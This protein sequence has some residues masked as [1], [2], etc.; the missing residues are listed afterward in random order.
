MKTRPSP[1]LFV[2]RTVE[3]PPQRVFEAWTE[4][5]HRLRWAC[6]EGAVLESAASELRVGGRHRLVMKVGDATHTAFGE[7]REIDPPH[8]LVYT[9]DWEEEDQRMGPTVVTVEFV[10]VDGGTEVRLSHSGFPDGESAEG[11]AEGWESCL[12]RLESFLG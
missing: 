3:A 6:P 5:E 4:E 9:W 10:A 1:T 2:T 12:S 8:R 11:H 7:Y